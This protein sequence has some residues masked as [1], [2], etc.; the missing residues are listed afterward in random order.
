MLVLHPDDFADLL[1][2]SAPDH[3]HVGGYYLR[4]DPHDAVRRGQVIV[5]APPKVELPPARGHRSGLQGIIARA[6]RA[7]E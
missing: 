7:F 4:R 5:L 2:I 6:W 1:D 3:A